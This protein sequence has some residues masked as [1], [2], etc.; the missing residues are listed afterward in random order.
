MAR[1]RHGEA[2]AQGGGGSA[3]V[4]LVKVVAGHGEAKE[5]E[6]GGCKA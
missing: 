5:K 2:G 3:M 6:V 1:A 4:S